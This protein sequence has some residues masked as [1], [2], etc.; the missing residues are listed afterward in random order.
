MHDI[1]FKENLLCLKNFNAY[2]LSLFSWF[3]FIKTAQITGSVLCTREKWKAIPLHNWTWWRKIFFS[4]HSNGILMTLL[5]FKIFEKCFI[6]FIREILLPCSECQTCKFKHIWAFALA[7]NNQQF[8]GYWTLK[9]KS[10]KRVMAHL[11]KFLKYF[12]TNV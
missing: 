10:Q 12:K 4:Y 5:I 2:N 11:A 3:R 1:G 8:D 9:R 6:V 7:F